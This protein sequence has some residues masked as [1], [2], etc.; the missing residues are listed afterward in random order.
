M[1]NMEYS[2]CVN[3]NIGVHGVSA[4]NSIDI[5]LKECS[6][7][8]EVKADIVINS[9]MNNACNVVRLWGQIKDCNGYPIPNSLLKLVKVE[10]CRGKCE[11]TGVAHTISDC[12]GFY[13]FDLCYYDG[14]ENYK[15][16]ASRTS[17]GGEDVVLLSGDGNCKV[18]SKNNP[19]IYQPCEPPNQIYRKMEPI[20]CNKQSD[21]NKHQYDDCD[22]FSN[23]RSNIYRQNC[24]Q[25]IN[26]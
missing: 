18:C 8:G 13:Q 14:N 21:C 5:K 20:N 19:N 1:N 6:K 7:V 22:D 2:N 24:R 17:S 15:I 11:Y 23:Y 3:N 4:G 16:L 9:D 10:M 12:E 26:I 25:S